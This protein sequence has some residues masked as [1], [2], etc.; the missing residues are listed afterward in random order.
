[1]RLPANSMVMLGIRQNPVQLGRLKTGKWDYL[2]PHSKAETSII[3]THKV[4]I[5]L[6]WRTDG[7]IVRRVSWPIVIRVVRL[8]WGYCLL[9]RRGRRWKVWLVTDGSSGVG[10]CC[11]VGDLLFVVV[12]GRMRVGHC[13]VSEDFFN[14]SNDADFMRRNGKK[15]ERTWKNQK[16]CLFAENANHFFLPVFLEPDLHAL[17]RSR[18]YFGLV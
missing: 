10:F 5:R 12:V 9:T 18:I 15:A 17:S 4:V 2:L 8:P 3:N 16:S 6:L 1:M 11:I 7:V 14:L 13:D